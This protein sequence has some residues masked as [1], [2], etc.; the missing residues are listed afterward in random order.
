VA[1]R[2]ALDARKLTD[3]GIGAYVEALV[4]GLS[5]RRDVRLTLVVR[6]GHR[7]RAA[8]MAREAEV[9]TLEAGGYTLRELVEL[10]IALRR[11]PAHVVHLPHFVVPPLLPG[12]TVVTVHDLIP[13]FYPPRPRRH[14]AMLY[15]RAMVRW[16]LGR[17]RRVITVSRTSRRDLVRFFGDPGDRLVVIPN[18]VDPALARRPPRAELS[19]LRERH[20][21]RPPLILVVGN[22]KPHKNV[23]T[24]LR[25]FHLAVRRHRLPGQL[26][27]VGGFPPGSDLERRAERMGLGGRV[28]CLGRL[29]TRELWGLYHL[30]AVL[31]HVALYEGFGLPILEAMAAGL[32]VIASNLGAMRELGE[33]AARLVHPLDVG[34][35]A[36][37][38]ERVLVDDPLRQRMIAAGRRRAA[39]LPWDR[40]VEAT[41][42]AYRA[43]A[44]EV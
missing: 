34:E 27:L 16:A 18:G 22:D 24:A 1:L 31:L 6:P 13:L 3:F 35:I 7:E 41:V 40:T 25:A 14:L 36:A 15:L 19:G 9:V 23:E 20:G 5:R 39:E 42:A 29:P 33:G 28:R 2:V 38:L 26:V 11:H 21:L 43:A 8:A 30:A 17:A 37:A 44:G 4:R 32:P 12:A 10:P